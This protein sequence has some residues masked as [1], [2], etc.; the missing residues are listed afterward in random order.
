MSLR[1][2]YPVGFDLDRYTSK[3]VLVQVIKIG[4]PAIILYFFS[5]PKSPKDAKWLLFRKNAGW[6]LRNPLPS[7]NLLGWWN[8]GPLINVY[9]DVFF[10]IGRLEL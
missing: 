2:L 8:S 4:A 10:A 6:L 1:F 5:T 3:L 7:V 9:M